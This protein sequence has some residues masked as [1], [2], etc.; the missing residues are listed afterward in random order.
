[1]RCP[2]RAFA[3]GV[4]VFGIAA[5]GGGDPP[6]S[7]PAPVVSSRRAQPVAS[8]DRLYVDDRAE[9]DEGRV[10]ITNLDEFRPW[11][12]RVTASAGDPPPLPNVDFQTHMVLLVSAG[13]SNAGD[14]V[15]V[16]SVGFEIQPLPSGGS[17]TI[18][19]AVVTTT[20][21]C[22]PFPGASYPTEVVRMP[23]ADPAIDW[24]E[25]RVEC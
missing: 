24:I 25:R 22:D 3:M 12:D 1:M 2:R 17:R 11:W 20:P 4:A 18:S 10:V 14:Q 6:P 5:C 7:A 9:M 8:A 21:D 15:R 16:D 23:R 19:F 13:P